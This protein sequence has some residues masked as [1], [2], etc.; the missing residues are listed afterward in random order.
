MSRFANDF[1]D[2]KNVWQGS[3]DRGRS[4]VELN[5]CEIEKW[6]ASQGFTDDDEEDEEEEEE[7]DDD[8]DE[9]E[10]EEEDGDDDDD[11]DDDDDGEEDEVDD[12]DQE[13]EDDDDDDDEEE[14]GEEEE[15]EDDDTLLKCNTA[16][17]A[18]NNRQ[19]VKEDANTVAGGVP[20]YLR[21]KP[22]AHL[23][24]PMGDTSSDIRYLSNLVGESSVPVS[25][26]PT[27]QLLAQD[28]DR[29]CLGTGTAMGSGTGLRTGMGS[30]MG[31]G[32][33]VI[34]SDDD[35]HQTNTQSN[36]T[37]NSSINNEVNHE[38]MN[39]DSGIRTK[40]RINDYEMVDE[41]DFCIINRSNDLNDT[42]DD[43]TINMNTNDS[44]EKI[45]FES[46]KCENANTNDNNDNNNS[47]HDN[48][49][50]FGSR[51]ANRMQPS[52]TDINTWLKPAKEPQG[53]TP[54]NITILSS[55]DFSNDLQ[56]SHITEINDDSDSGR[57]VAS[58]LLSEESKTRNVGCKMYKNESSDIVQNIADNGI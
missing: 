41:D 17:T 7:D 51:S 12:H 46:A 52:V 37:I 36:I 5:L 54:L 10:E 9:E 4:S 45:N 6:A 11:D 33:G 21:P 50:I 38:I 13:E 39:R 26:T 32:S 1:N 49:R 2:A 22:P 14:E 56:E 48:S 24:R 35:G 34:K 27:S 18:G 28:L 15:E 30:G 20:E 3:A 58:N 57:K 53:F 42:S 25:R 55:I 29:M 8:D 16:I 23:L 47:N 40:S 44:R 31:S 19:G 43:N